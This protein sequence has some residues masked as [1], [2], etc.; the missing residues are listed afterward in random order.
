MPK[1]SIWHAAL[2]GS[3]RSPHRVPGSPS[4]FVHSWRSV[5][6]QRKHRTCV[7]SR[8]ATSPGAAN[9]GACGRDVRGLERPGDLRVRERAAAVSRVVARAI[10]EARI[11]AVGER[12][13]TMA[14]LGHPCPDF[15]AHRL[16]SSNGASRC[17]RGNRLRAVQRL[18]GSRPRAP[19]RSGDGLRA[20]RALPGTQPLLRA[21]TRKSSFDALARAPG[22]LAGIASA[23]R[24]ASSRAGRI[25]D[26]ARNRA[27]MKKPRSKPLMPTPIECPERITSILTSLEIS[28]D[29]IAARSL[30]LHPEAQELV[31]AETGD[32]GREYLLTPAAAAKWRE[33]SAA[34]LFHGGIN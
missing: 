33:M 30:V 9:R 34:A 24:G 32:D 1:A 8:P 20:C 25:A 12:P 27:H 21:Q 15:R 4:V 5:G 23:A 17:A 7:S 26:A 11:E 3:V 29:L 14:Q 13:G 18:L 19:S 31:V 16:R 28:T 6:V 22:F 2:I 10:H